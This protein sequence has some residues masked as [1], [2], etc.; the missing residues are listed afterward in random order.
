MSFLLVLFKVCYW[1]WYIKENNSFFYYF[2]LNFLVYVIVKCCYWF[3]REL[4][5]F[6][7]GDWLFGVGIM[8][9]F[10][11]VEEII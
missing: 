8:Y 2:K 7:F 9:F 3:L 1:E 5:G 11:I 10:I 6:D 4:N